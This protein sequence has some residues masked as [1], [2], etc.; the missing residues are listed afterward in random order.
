MSTV[1]TWQKDMQ[2]YP[3]FMLDFPI[4][5]KTTAL[6]IVDMQYY[7]ASPDY[8]I[9][10]VINKSHPGLAD[11]YNSS[12]KVVA[13]NCR[14]LLDFFRA[15]RLRVFYVSFGALLRDGSDMLPLRKR[16]KDA[17]AFTTERFEYQILDELKPAPGD[18]VINKTTRCGFI[19]TCLDHTMRM[20]GV[21][22]VVIAGAQTTGCVES[23]ARGA[24]D[25]GYKTILIDD[26]CAAW[27]E[28]D[29]NTTM[30]NFAIFFGKVM[31]TEELI[32]SLSQKPG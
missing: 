30:R 14:R 10:Q 2:K 19:G 7:D 8:G 29:Q 18:L 4:N 5:P 21:D 11:Y 31:D 13:A 3:N 24:T 15:N 27:T 6:L 22:T 26:A 1:K 12:L 9:G 25:L 23:T 32:Q 16:T 17:P 20:A 28:A